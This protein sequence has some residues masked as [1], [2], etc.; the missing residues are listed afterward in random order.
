MM[1][2]D[3]TNL[4]ERVVRAYNGRYESYYLVSVSS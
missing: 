3:F 4:R 2:T 1:T